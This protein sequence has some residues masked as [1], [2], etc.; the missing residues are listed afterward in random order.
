MEGRP[1]APARLGPCLHGAWAGAGGGYL[2]SCDGGPAVPGNLRDAEALVRPVFR[3]NR[4]SIVLNDLANGAVWDLSTQRKVDD[5]SSVKPPPV[6]D[7]SDREQDDQQ[8][9]LRD[10]P[11]K[12]VDDTLGARPGRTTVLHVLD[13][14]SDPAGDI[15]SISAISV[16]EGSP[17]TLAIA[18]DAQTVQVTLPPGDAVPDLAFGYTIDDG[19]GLTATAAVNVRVRSQQ[20]NEPPALREGHQPLPH[21]VPAGGSVSLPVL[22]E[23][24]DFDGDPVVLVEASA[25][26]GSVTTTATGFVGFTA[27]LEPGRQSLTYRV[28]EGRGDPVEAAVDVTVQPL[29]ATPV[30]AVAQPD[31]ARGQVGRPVTIRPLD[32]D[33]PGSDPTD[34]DAVVALAGELAIPQD[35][36]LVTDVGA[37]TVTLTPSRP[38]PFLLEYGVAFGNA[39]YA[40][41][42]IRVDVAAAPASPQPPVAV[43]DSAVLHAQVPATVD[44]LANDFSPSGALLAVQTATPV[45]DNAQVQVAIVRGRWLRINAL[46]PQ[47]APNP[48]VVRYTITDGVTG[49][50]TG[51]VTVTQLGPPA[52]DTPVPKDDRATVRAGDTV[53]IPVLDNDT[54]PS[55]S[56]ITLRANVSGAPGVGRLNVTAQSGDQQDAGTAYVSGQVVRFVAPEAVDTPRTVV[57]EYVAQNPGGDQAVGQAH[58][59]I[60]PAPSE[61]AP[62][63]APAP[64][65]VDARVVAGSTVVIR[66]PVTGADPDGDSVTVTGIGS[67]AQLGR[68]L[69][70]GAGSLTYQAY[71]ASA[72]TDSVVYRV[73]DRYGRTGEATIR[74]AVVPPG[75]PQPPVA[76]DDVVTA[77]PGARLS[78]G[79]LGNDLLDPDAPATVELLG[80]DEAELD[81]RFV[82]VTAPDATGVPLVVLYSVTNGFGDPAVATLTVRSE[83]GHNIPPTA[84]DA[85]AEPEPDADTVDVDLLAGASD[86][87]G[88][89]GELEISR[90]YDPAAQVRGATVTLPVGE[91]PRVIAFEVRDGDGATAVGLVHVPASGAGAPY[92]RA[93]TTITVPADGS[94]T[95]AVTDHVVDPAGKP[96]S[97]TTADRIWASP[98]A[99]LEVRAEGTGSL[100]LTG[101]PGYSG[102]AAITFEVTNGASLTD[103]EASTAVITVPVQVGPDTPFLRCPETPLSVIAGGAPISVDVTSLCRVWVLDRA[104]LDGLRYTGSWAQDPGGVALDGGG[105]RTLRLEATGA[106][107][108]GSMGAVEVGVQG[109]EGVSARL[110]VQVRAAPVPSVNPVTVDGV[111]A[112]ATADIDIAPYVRSRLRDPDISVVRVTQLEGMPA[113]ASTAGSRVRISP[114]GG[115]HGAMTFGVIVTD[116]ADQSRSD[117]HATG[118]V[119][120]RV[121]GVPDAPG[122]PAPGRTVL[123][124]V[125]ELSWAA[126]ANNGAPIDQYEVQYDGGSQVCPASPCTITGL[127]NGTEYVF[128][129]RAHNLV[130]WGEPSAPSAPARPNTVPGAVTG[131]VTSDPRDG[132]LRL[133]WNEPPN[134]GTP[135]QRYEVTW[136]G[137]GRQT[138][139]GTSVTATGLDNDNRYTFTVIAVNAQGPGPAATVE[140]QSAG[141]PAAPAAPTFTATNRAGSSTRVAVVSWTAVGPNGPGPTTYTLTRNGATVCADVTATTCSDDGIVNDGTIYTYTVTASNA[142]GHRSAPSPGA[143]MEATATPDPITGFTAQPTGVDGQARIRYDVGASHGSTSI[144]SCTWSGGSCGE[145]THDPGGEDGVSRLVNGLPNGTEVAIGLQACN[146]GS[147]SDSYAGNPCNT[148]V[149]APVTTYGPLR[150]LQITTSADGEYVDFTVSVNPNGKAATVTIETSRQTQTFTTCVCAWSWSGRDQVG[151]NSSDTIRVTVSD[152]GRAPLTAS[153]TQNTGPPPPPPPS[154]SVARGGPCGTACA[155][156]CTDPSCS[157]IVV[158][159]AN[160]GGSVTCTFDSDHGPGGF[161]SETYGPN[162]SRQSGNWYGYPGTRVYV[163]CGGVTGTSPP[164]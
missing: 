129:V 34:P 96:L 51:E 49:P 60:N 37:G 45:A 69:E 157:W 144:V 139:T 36:T 152:P 118:L 149:S 7:D 123:S 104:T 115:S 50:V 80:T 19:R 59:T 27:P 140:G 122:A 106:A 14:D 162:E 163:T 114:S 21:T 78:V 56:P 138:V 86:Q 53:A 57:V 4:N 103:P 131:L 28:S 32:N 8:D 130:G 158:T 13:N 88:R 161:V 124:R 23:W 112:G 65:Q 55:G 44:V 54:T 79:V 125:V 58:V 160:F 148:A 102:P 42:A 47:I 155:S 68:V 153:R 151:Y 137:G 11:P 1:A 147:G 117:R 141:P 105:S 2:R 83:E 9:D 132:S 111:R 81:D 64:S 135:V 30:A 154:V 142:I 29:D 97:L 91:F 43:P 145:W 33:L 134:D 101:K 16:P 93:G 10:Q 38:G 6:I 95:V 121:L 116:V 31:V 119:T 39:P 99:G 5:W 20:E 70:L 46:V 143:R 72:G 61:A 90:V 52:D 133:S 159:T 92:P 113:S 98:A 12:A 84:G 15:L 128:R 48:Q 66:V 120:L 22:T 40:T 146:G 136:T 89:A 100:V 107:V 67:A 110:A 41:G 76:V 127:D 82:R 26:A 87:D 94:T 18:P 108:P 17:A 24:R 75:E 35:A 73:T 156:T 63:K 62:N 74:I 150:D 25:P 3:L 126:P 164:W 85:S 71:P 77:A 109:F